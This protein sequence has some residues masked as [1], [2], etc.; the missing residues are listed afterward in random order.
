MQNYVFPSFQYLLMR[1]QNLLQQS[2]KSKKH[3]KHKLLNS[4][5]VR[6]NVACPVHM[7]PPLSFQTASS[8]EKAALFSEKLFRHPGQCF[9]NFSSDFLC[10]WFY[11]ALSSSVSTPSLYSPGD[12]DSKT[13]YTSSMQLSLGNI[14]TREC[15]ELLLDLLIY[16]ENQTGIWART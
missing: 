14:A 5:A 4:R 10:Y 3:D 15:Y 16:L 6:A 13:H 12:T 9:P 1:K 8:L 7:T 11:E 2:L